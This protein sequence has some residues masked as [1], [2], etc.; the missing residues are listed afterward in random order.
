MLKTRIITALALGSAMVATVL[1]LPTWAAAAVLGLLWI[2]GVWEWAYFVGGHSVPPA[3]YAAVFVG[4][5]LVGGPLFDTRGAI[6]VAS[7][8]VAWWLLASLSLWAYPWRIPAT[9]VAASGPVALLPAWFLLAFIHGSVPQGPELTLSLLI[10]VW[11]ADVG[12]YF[13]G[14]LFGR[15]K[16]APHISSGKTWEGVIGG[17][18]AAALAAALAGI[19]LGVALGAF[20][21]IALAVT[22]ASVI[23][24]LTVSMFKRNVGLKDSGRLLP[25]HGGVLD[26][27]DSLAAAV[28]IFFIGLSVAGLSG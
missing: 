5:M 16:L 12:A 21:A 22:M 17:L 27:I 2:A 11:A 19:G 7:V 28:P 1:L 25:G 14:R 6:L 13:F 26:R 20:V 9:V 15:V 3:A 10:I 8:A 18:A 24:D 23:G 4:L